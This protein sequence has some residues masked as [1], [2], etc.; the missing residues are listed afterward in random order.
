MLNRAEDVWAA[1]K[2]L[3]LPERKKLAKMLETPPDPFREVGFVI[4]PEEVFELISETGLKFMKLAVKESK[5]NVQLSRKLKRRKSDPETIRRNVEICDLRRQDSRKWSQ[6][7]LAKKY[8]V[9][10][11]LIRSVLKNEHKWR[12][13]AARLKR[14][15]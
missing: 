6:G 9:T 7:R 2:A 8:H 3:G 4:V 14:S 1:I 10:A 5:A 13:S 11:R 12:E 15:D